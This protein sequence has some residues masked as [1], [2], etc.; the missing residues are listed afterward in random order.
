MRIT[1][2]CR[3]LFLAVAAA[4]LPAKTPPSLMPGDW[5]QIR[6]EYQRHRQAVFPVK[7]G[8]H[9]AHNYGQRWTAGFDG[10]GFTV[11]PDAGAWR[12]GLQL[13][14]YGFPG[15]ERRVTKAHAAPDVEKFSYQWD[16]NLEEW[17]VNGRNGLEHGFTLAARPG[18]S[19]APL[20]LHLS[21]LGTL[22][23]R[24][25][26][27]GHN[28]TFEDGHSA[29]VNYNGLKV[30]DAK[31]HLLP[32]RFVPESQGLRL[33][34]DDRSAQYPLTIDPVA[35]Q[36][37]YFKASNT[38]A[39]DAFGSVVA[40]SGDTLVVGAWHEDSSSAGVNSTSN[41]LAESAGAVYVF[42]RTAGVWSQQA[43]LKASNPQAFDAFGFSVAISGDTIVVGAFSEDSSTT[44]VNSI[45]N[46]SGN[47]SGAAYVFTRTAGAWS[48][49]AYLKASN[50]SSADRFGSSV[51]IDGDT[52][53]IGASHESDDESGAAYVFTRSAGV[54]SQQ[55]YLKA[56]NPG[57]QDEFGW[58]VALSGN[59][60]V[61]GAISEDSSSAGVNSVPNE[62]SSGAG[63]AYV[64]TRTAGVWSHQAYL[65]ASNPGLYDG[66]GYS[67]A[68]DGDTLV[69]G[70]P[71]EDSSVPSSGAAYVFTR[72]GGGVWAQQAYLKASVL[73][74][75]HFGISVGIAGDSLVVGQ[76]GGQGAAYLFTRTLGTW[77]QAARLTPNN[78]STADHF[79]TSVAISG[80]LIAAGAPDEDSSS[81]GVNSTPNESAN[82]AGA[83]YV[84]IR[85]LPVNITV[86]SIPSGLVFSSTGSDCSPGSPYTT[87]SQLIWRAGLICDLY[88]TS[89]QTGAPGTR[90]L[91]S[92]WENGATFP[93]RSI[94]APNVDSTY[95]ANFTTQHLLITTRTGSGSVTPSSDFRNAGL[96]DVTAT[97]AACSAFTGWSGGTVTAGQINLTAPTTLTANFSAPF[98]APV[99]IGPLQTVRGT[100]GRYRQ[101]ISVLNSSGTNAPVSVI[102]QSFGYAATVAPAAPT[103]T[104]TACTGP[105][106]R[107]YYTVP[108]V[109]PGAYGTVTFDF[110][111]PNRGSVAYNAFGLVGAGP[112]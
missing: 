83:A 38:G 37:A 69:V 87:P 54:W 61:V 58:S 76:E 90:Y 29:V 100:P 106:A 44:G 75:S 36:E 5:S 78:V 65:K 93:G 17:F 66:F 109:A 7:G 11:T 111:A 86:N 22:T 26:A 23:P 67:V 47:N 10:R 9:H 59:T 94:N 77:S 57:F 64:F 108:T 21:V 20:M 25:S 99:V 73:D 101:T 80:E 40:L 92:Q 4:C 89:P 112:R 82:S 96:V 27:D 24:V 30:N 16:S 41:E 52:A 45:P 50:A 3:F 97:P 31:G 107:P 81:V 88:F 85:P 71:D 102:L 14:S 33:E 2:T 32:A 35:T 70:T 55:A 6:A 15:Q 105:A 34:I 48:Q 43:Y 39:N 62:S 53:V 13:D 110:T 12:W 72:S 42:T 51:A 19:D 18:G 46:E 68:I 60:L 8:G 63:A 98:D 56:S 103:G 95:T 79:A 91:F 28:V 104:T 49:Q 84:F 74:Y 1:M